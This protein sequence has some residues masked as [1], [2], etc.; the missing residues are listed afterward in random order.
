MDP[1]PRKHLLGLDGL[2]GVAAMA[3]VAHHV[4]VLRDWVG[5]FDHAYL[6]VD[7]FFLLSGYVLG[8]AYEGR[9]NRGLGVLEYLRIRL[10]RLMPM[11]AV[12]ALLGACY[13]IAM[14]EA[15]VTIAMIFV[16][17]VAF[18]PIVSGERGLYPLNDVQ[19]S[20]LFELLINVLHALL[21]RL[22]TTARL[23]AWVV[24]SGAAL[25]AI[26]QHYQTLDVGWNVE[27]FPGGIFR[28]AFAFPA[29]LLVY[30]LQA[31]GR[32]PT[33]RTPYAMVVVAL[34][35]MLALPG[36]APATDWVFV[37]V[38]FPALMLVAIHA[39]PPRWM[40]RPALWAGAVSYPL[41][42]IHD[43]LL[44]IA[45]TLRPA[46]GSELLRMG[47]WAVA[48]G[49]I[50]VIASWVERYIDRPARLMLTTP[51]GDRKNRVG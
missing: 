25:I 32:L 40:N 31:I 34:A 13:W 43:P 5:P 50:I 8:L 33:I 35:S 51:A 12:G 26:N 18:I 10:I 24:G 1:A 41:Y 45:V 48:V 3:V 27:N 39:E 7:F 17:Q 29:G 36:F 30:R 6:A 21:F 19:W 46:D 22:A 42:A 14:R 28:V 2:R 38:A 20:L 11:V 44:D 9:F 4:A 23:V 16:L 49:L 37:I 15:P 47:F